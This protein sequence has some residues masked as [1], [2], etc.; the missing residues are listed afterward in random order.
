MKFSPVASLIDRATPGLTGGIVTFLL[1][2]F[3]IFLKKDC[4]NDPLHPLD[5][6]DFFFILF[7]KRIHLKVKSWPRYTCEQRP[8]WAPF[9][10]QIAS[11]ESLV[12]LGDGQFDAINTL[13]R[14][15][16][17]TDAVMQIG[18]SLNISSRKC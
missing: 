8:N 13:A 6:R 7:K 17:S 14:F 18:S 10:M 12:G 2:K 5:G 4:R 11:I 3:D 16:T 15:D 9:Y 1:K